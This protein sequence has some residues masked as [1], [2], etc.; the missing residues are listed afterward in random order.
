[1]PTIAGKIP[2]FVIPSFGIAVRNSQLIT[3]IPRTTLNPKIITRIATTM[4][5]MVP[6]IVKAIFCLSCFVVNG[7]WLLVESYWLLVIGYWL[8]VIGYWL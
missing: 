2:P 8:L 7:Y 1:V 6:K 4:K 3:P 5:L